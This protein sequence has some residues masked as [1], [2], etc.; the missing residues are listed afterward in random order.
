MKKNICLIISSSLIML[1]F[2]ACQSDEASVY[3][4]NFKPE[5]AQ[6]YEEIARIY[7]EETGINVKITTAASG[8]Y[9]QTLKSEIAK[10]DAPTIFQING[11]VGYETWKDYTEDLSDSEIYSHLIDKDLAISDETGV[12]GIPFAIE[13][14]GII[15][16]E[17]ILN[18]YFA[19]DGAKITSI[20]EIVNFETLQTAVE[21]MQERKDEL[22]IEGVFAS[23]SLI[24]GED[25]R[26]TTHLANIPLYYEFNETNADLS[27]VE[28]TGEIEFSYSSNLQNLFDLYLNNSI[29]NSKQ[30]GTKSVDDSMAEFALGKV[31]MVQ[32]GNWAWSQISGIDG[33][34]VQ[35]DSIKF[36]PMYTGIEGEE[37]QGLSIG[38]ENYFCI[39]SN[40]SEEDKQASLD[41]LNWLYTSETGKAFI[42]DEL[43]FIAPFD[44]F[45]EDEVPDDPL[46]KEILSWS[47]NEN[48]TNLSWN[49]TIFPSQVWKD[50]FGADLLSYAQDNTSW[51]EVVENAVQDWA[52]EK[53][54]AS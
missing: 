54:L 6:E 32:N 2:V 48:V 46:A 29:T 8:N 15:Y 5:V 34:V 26:W 7:T 38:T 17:E 28:G 31:A 14:Y 49:F 42:T 47:E 16:N 4:L 20:D 30:L 12:Y 13:G 50:N 9:E 51:D 3:F 44:S 19:L 1:S 53:S 45:E 21:D 40:A 43:G 25:W 11:P 24:S 52:K 35:E 18:E 37:S 23:T 22:G 33:N 39:N 27:T 10:S 36:L 41:F